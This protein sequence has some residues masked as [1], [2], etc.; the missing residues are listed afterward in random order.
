MM[1]AKR[2][3]QASLQENEG[4]QHANS[5]PK[6]SLKVSEAKHYAKAVLPVNLP[7]A[8]AKV[9]VSLVRQANIRMHRERQTVKLVGPALQ[10]IYALPAILVHGQTLRLQPALHNIMTSMVKASAKFARP[11]IRVLPT[12]RQCGVS[13]GMRCRPACTVKNVISV[14]LGNIRMRTKAHVYHAAPGRKPTPP[15]VRA[16][17]VRQTMAPCRKNVVSARVLIVT[18]AES[19]VKAKR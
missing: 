18:R 9:R 1:G 13:A 8:P 4:R 19:V 17:L 14:R 11:D 5:A 10:W 15:E 3:D 12:P 7:L 6:A 16:R 2:V